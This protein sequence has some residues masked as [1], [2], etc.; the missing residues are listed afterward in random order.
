[1]RREIKLIEPAPVFRGTDA[2]LAGALTRSQLRGP[3]VRR[4]FQGVYALA[5]EP[6]TPELHCATAAL[7]LPRK[8]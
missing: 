2:V 4:L 1:M 5:S 7:T 3:A 8:R 6:I